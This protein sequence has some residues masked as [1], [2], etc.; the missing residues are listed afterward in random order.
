MKV[1][2]SFPPRQ[3][4]GKHCPKCGDAVLKTFPTGF[5]IESAQV[6]SQTPDGFIVKDNW[7]CPA[8][9]HWEYKRKEV[10]PNGIMKPRRV[11]SSD[12]SK[13]KRSKRT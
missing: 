7:H 13:K 11:D 12:K 1:G 6:V 5:V 4:R 2:D 8:C 9:G 3:H 10:T